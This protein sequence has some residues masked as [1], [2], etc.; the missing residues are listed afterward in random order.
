MKVEQ[1]LANGKITQRKLAKLEQ[2]Q[3]SLD[4]ERYEAQMIFSIMDDYDTKMAA[5]AYPHCHRPI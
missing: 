4:L 1:S 3:H 5:T 2:L